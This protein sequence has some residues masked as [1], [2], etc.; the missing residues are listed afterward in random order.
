[1]PGGLVEYDT[2][3]MKTAPKRLVINYD[4]PCETANCARPWID[5][6]LLFEKTLLKEL[7]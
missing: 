3:D 4:K 2:C 7:T 1:M 6:I 5:Q